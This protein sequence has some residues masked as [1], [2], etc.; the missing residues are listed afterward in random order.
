[1]SWARFDDAFG[2][3][4]KII[5]LSDSAFRLYVTAILYCSHH[6]TD[7][8]VPGAWAKVK[9][10]RKTDISELVRAGLWHTQGTDYRVHD[11]LE[12][13]PTRRQVETRKQQLSAQR[14]EAGRAGG[15]ASGE[16]KRE[17]NVQ[18]N[19]SPIPSRTHIRS[20]TSSFHEE[21]AGDA[22]ARRSGLRPISGAVAAILR[23]AMPG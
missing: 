12:Y 8:V 4:P 11:Y 23:E 6:L 1:M 9:A 3:H 7:G 2:E 14:A 5:G 18:Q 21:N 15:I 13:Q 20:S 19:G 22:R 10:R 16:S 17:A